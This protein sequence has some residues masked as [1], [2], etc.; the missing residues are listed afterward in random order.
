MCQNV[1]G[2][3]CSPVKQWSNGVSRSFATKRRLFWGSRGRNHSFLVLPQ[4]IVLRN[5]C[6]ADD[7]SKGGAGVG[8]KTTEAMRVETAGHWEFRE[9]RVQVKA[10]QQAVQWIDGPDKT[11]NNYVGTEDLG[12]KPGKHDSVRE[13]EAPHLELHELELEQQPVSQERK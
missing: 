8:S 10:K 5:R 13:R 4:G 12:A 3:Y 2:T 7:G 1:R 11:N 6:E 9:A